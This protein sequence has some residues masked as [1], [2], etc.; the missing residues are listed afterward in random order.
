MPS[1]L[2]PELPKYLL[3]SFARRQ[4]RKRV[5]STGKFHEK[6]STKEAKRATKSITLKAVLKNAALRKRNLGSLCV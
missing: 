4:R 6:S 5:G 3:N 2:E 1:I